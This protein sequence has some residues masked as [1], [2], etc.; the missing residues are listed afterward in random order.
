MQ[1]EEEKIMITARL[2]KSLVDWIDS[3]SRIA[4]VNS[5]SRITRT[6][7]V[8]GFLSM[9]RSIVEHQEKTQW[10]MSHQDKI[11]E[12]LNLATDKEQSQ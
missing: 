1:H 8:V 5:E 11:K 6:D 4:A 9:M 2:P 12:A 3:Y 7:T 10:G